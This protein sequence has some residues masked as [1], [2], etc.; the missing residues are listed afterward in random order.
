MRQ[1]PI[2]PNNPGLSRF[3]AARFLLM[4]VLGFYLGGGAIAVMYYGYGINPL[5]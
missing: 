1:Q 2:G 4:V 5:K 3:F